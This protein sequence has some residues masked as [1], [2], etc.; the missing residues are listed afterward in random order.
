MRAACA[1]PPCSRSWSGSRQR[2]AA[3]CLTS[4]A[5]HPL[6]PQ[7]HCRGQQIS[8][9]LQGGELHEALPRSAL[10]R[11]RLG[12]RAGRLLQQQTVS[13]RTQTGQRRGHRPLRPA[14]L[15]RQWRLLEHSP[16]HRQG[17]AWPWGA[18]GM[19]LRQALSQ[20]QRGPVVCGQAER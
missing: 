8:Q 13:A 15:Q 14:A 7:L 20:C 18:I 1:C 3:C 12:V 9:S 5:L 19:Q 4:L 10:P 17:K 16:A 2:L 11:C 6:P